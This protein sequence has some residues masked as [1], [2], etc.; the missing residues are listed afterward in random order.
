MNGCVWVSWWKST[1]HVN[2]EAGSVPSSE[3]A[4]EPAYAIT[5]PPL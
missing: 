4:P 1:R 3:S 5:L 2:A